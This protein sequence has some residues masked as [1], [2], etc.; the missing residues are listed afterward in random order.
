MTTT[1]ATSDLGYD[2]YDHEL[3]RD[4]W[5]TFARLRE[6]APLLYNEEH[7]F[8]ALSRAEDIEKAHVDRETFINRRGDTLSVLKRGVEVPPGTVIFEDPPTHAIHRALLSRMFTP[9][10]VLEL[11]PRIRELCTSL[12]EP[13]ADAKEFDFMADIG[14]QLPMLVISTLVGIPESDQELIRD[15]Y[16]ASKEREVEDR[17][18]NLSGAIFAKYVDERAAN[19]AGDIMSTLLHSEFQDFDGVTR[20]LS[21]EEV[22]AYVNIVA[23]AGND[24]TAIL[25]GWMA[26]V[27]AE[28]PDQ[29]RLLVEDP[30][31]I[32]NAVD[33]LARFEPPPLQSC[34]YVARDIELHGQIVPEGS[35]M[36]L[37]IA[38]ANRDTDRYDD[39][40]RFDVRRD[41]RQYYTFGFGAHFCLG[42]ALAKLEMRVLLEELLPRIPEWDVDLDRAVFGHKDPDLRPWHTMPAVVG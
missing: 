35:I 3:A 27:L 25:I 31:L 24:T 2:P 19:P 5:A 1:D 4:P 23:A 17:G 40:D 7:D 42:Q 21:R 39:P 37:L 14:R 29:R 9:R 26:K 41:L 28:H 30:S 34:R 12:V 18:D 15:H 38:S 20:T 13:L 8:W 32:G 33:E 36:A 11:E 10:R 6:E 22:L 16:L